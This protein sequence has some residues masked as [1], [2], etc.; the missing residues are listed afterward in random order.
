MVAVLFAR[1]DSHYREFPAADV[2][3]IERDARTWPGGC[4]VIAHPPCRAWGRLKGMAKPVSGERELATWAMDQARRW[5]GVV[6][7]PIDSD[8]WAASRCLGW[9]I[10][11]DFGG[12]LLPVLQCWWGHR[13]PKA[14]GLYVVG[15]DDVPELPFDVTDPGGRVENMCRAERER[16]TQPMAAWL[17]ELAARCRSSCIEG[18]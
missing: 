16:T 11:D 4:Q 6:E 14:T 9:G 15:I 12:L 1:A 3:D 18:V 7:H 5:G 13:A 2:W 10:R 8:L 17:L